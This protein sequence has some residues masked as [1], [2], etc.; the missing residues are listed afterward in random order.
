MHGKS[1]LR[2]ISPLVR[3][4]LK[5]GAMPAA[6]CTSDQQIPSYK[7]IKDRGDLD[8]KRWGTLKERRETRFARDYDL[9]Q[10]V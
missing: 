9:L 3:G 6:A 1:L 7:P 10:S 4:K 2:P 8:E 5:G